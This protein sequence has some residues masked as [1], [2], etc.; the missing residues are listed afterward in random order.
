VAKAPGVPTTPNPYYVVQQ[1]QYV[2]PRFFFIFNSQQSFNLY[3]SNLSLTKYTN[4][5]E[6]AKAASSDKDK[7]D[8]TQL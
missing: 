6:K 5:K 4:S 1:D 3:A 7:V 8:D 2:M